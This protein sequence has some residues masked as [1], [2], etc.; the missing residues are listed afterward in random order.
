MSALLRATV[1]AVCNTICLAIVGVW[2]CAF[3][4]IASAAPTLTDADSAVAAFRARFDAMRGQFAASPFKR[5]LVLES[6]QGS[7]DVSGDVYAVVPHPFAHVSAALGNA[8]TWCDILI[9]H[10]NTKYCQVQR[11][12]GGTNLQ[13]NVGKKF[14]QPLGDSYRLTFAWRAAVQRADFLKVNLS[15]DT[16]PLSTR[17]YRIT[18]EA[19]PLD[20]GNTFVHLSYAFGFSITGR[21]AMKAYL[22]TIGRNKVGFTVTGKDARG[23]PVYVDGIRGLVERNTMRYHLAVEAYL[24]ASTPALALTPRAQFEKRLV[25]WFTAAE[26]YPRQLHEMEQ[27]EYLEMKR[28]EYQRQQ[29]DTGPVL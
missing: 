1:G 28:R 21:L 19:V 15:A 5:P 17:D 4:A 8:G 26:L 18:L 7:N 6:Q 13:M 27:R 25:D 2:L 29:A 14:D 12:A 11:G 23:Q 9:L 22:A 20:G 10:L 3:A 16:G 24:G